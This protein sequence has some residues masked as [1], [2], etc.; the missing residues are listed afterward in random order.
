MLPGYKT[1]GG[2]LSLLHI[3]LLYWNEPPQ[4]CWRFNH[5][6][7][8]SQKINQKSFYTKKPLRVHWQIQQPAYKVNHAGEIDSSATI[9]LHKSNASGLELPKQPSADRR[10]S[11]KRVWRQSTESV[12]HRYRSPLLGFQTTQETASSGTGPA[13]GQ[14]QDSGAGVRDDAALGWAGLQAGSAIPSIRSWLPACLFKGQW[15]FIL[16]PQSYG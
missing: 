12:R 11:V 14:V 8:R 6:G 16:I 3:I 9:F 1:R 7:G 2:I 10:S 15:V 13:Y 4:D 5:L